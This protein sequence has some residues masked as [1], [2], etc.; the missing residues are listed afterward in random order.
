MKPNWFSLLAA[1]P[2]AFSA[3]LAEA[4]S[5]AATKSHGQRCNSTNLTTPAYDK[6]ELEFRN[7]FH[8]STAICGSVLLLFWQYF[9]RHSGY[10]LS[11]RWWHSTDDVMWILMGL[12]SI[13]WTAIIPVSAL[14]WD[15]CASIGIEVIFRGWNGYEFWGRLAFSPWILDGVFVWWAI[16]RIIQMFSIG[17]YTTCASCVL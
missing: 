14:Y 2:T 15:H 12:I 13:S 5:E 7:T 3:P 10:T 6:T 1:I 4:A 16:R 11:R 9:V 8:L 17:M